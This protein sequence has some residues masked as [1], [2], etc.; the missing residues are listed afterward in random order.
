VERESGGRRFPPILVGAAI[1]QPTFSRGLKNTTFE[2]W[3]QATPQAEVL[4]ETF[5]VRWWAYRAGNDRGVVDYMP[6]SPG[7]GQ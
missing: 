2:V 5:R 7:L 4:P 1:F 6:P 3:A